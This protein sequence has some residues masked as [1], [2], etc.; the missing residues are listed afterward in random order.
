MDQ[1]HR[2]HRPSSL[3][4]SPAS[5]FAFTTPLLLHLAD[6]L[7]LYSRGPTTRP[8]PKTLKHPSARTW[9]RWRGWARVGGVRSSG[10]PWRCRRWPR[11]R[12][13][14]PGSHVGPRR[15]V[16]GWE[17][18]MRPHTPGV[19]AWLADG[20]GRPRGLRARG[21]RRRRRWPRRGAGRRPPPRR[22]WRSPSL[23]IRFFFFGHSYC[24]WIRILEMW[25]YI[26]DGSSLARLVSVRMIQLQIR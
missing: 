6:A 23:A 2:H 10:Q 5:G 8:P 22:W 16:L 17:M 9:W 12:R 20:E 14:S 11:R 3:S 4:L 26:V 24:L 15:G 21:W 18:A 13:L 19:D 1:V 7:S 25:S